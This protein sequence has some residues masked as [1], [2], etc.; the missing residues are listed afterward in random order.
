MES[1]KVDSVTLVVGEE[2][3]FCQFIVMDKVRSGSVLLHNIVG[4]NGDVQCTN[5]SFM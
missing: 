4:C 2:R 5:S 3:L 1:P